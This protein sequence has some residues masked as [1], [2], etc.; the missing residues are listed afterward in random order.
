M[1]EIVV[2]NS[3]LRKCLEQ[4][5]GMGIRVTCVG[6]IDIIGDSKYD[7][8]NRKVDDKARVHSETVSPRVELCCEQMSK[9]GEESETQGS[10]AGKSDL[11]DG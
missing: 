9:S 6:A 2:P 11:G 7:K 8:N 10:E 5:E 4:L 1:E 3:E